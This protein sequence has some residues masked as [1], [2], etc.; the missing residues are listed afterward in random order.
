MPGIIFIYTPNID[1]L[2]FS[3]LKE[4]NNLLN[5]HH[6]FYFNKRSF[7]F[8]CTKVN[9]KVI[10]TQYKGLDIGDIYGLMNREKN[11]KAAN[12]LKKN[13]DYLQNFVDRTNFSNHIRFVIKNK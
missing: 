7:E 5:P 11:F 2:G 3:Y 8:M 10:E 9:M 6:L 12:Y 1:S 13:F 4:K